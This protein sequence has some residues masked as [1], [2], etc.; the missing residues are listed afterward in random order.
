MAFQDDF[1]LHILSI[2]PLSLLEVLRA[3]IIKN[4]SLHSSFLPAELVLK[5]FYES[6]ILLNLPIIQLT[7]VISM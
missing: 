7:V 3:Y 4:I 6:Y 1:R 5:Y 2:H